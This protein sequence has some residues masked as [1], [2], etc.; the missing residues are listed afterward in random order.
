MKVRIFEK[1]KK[2]YSLDSRANRSG[3][4]EASRAVSYLYPSR[5]VMPKA[6]PSAVC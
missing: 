1:G 5:C 3:N 2:R 6:F 4:C